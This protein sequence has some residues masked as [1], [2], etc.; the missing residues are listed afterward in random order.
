MKNNYYL[1]LI[2]IFTLG[3]IG[4]SSCSSDDDEV[5]TTDP[6]TLSNELLLHYAF[7][8]NVNDSSI[9]DYNG[10]NFGATFTN[11][12]FGNAASAV[13]FDGVDDYIDLPN[14]IQ[15]K[16]NLP[17]SIA[18][19]IRYDSQDVSDRD[20]FNT[21]FEENRDTGIYYNSQSSTGNYAVNFGDG[22]NNYLSSTRRTYVAD[23]AIEV[24]VWHHVAI[25]ITSG[26]NMD[27][28]IDGVKT[29]GTYSGSGGDLEYSNTSGSI[30][31]HDRSMTE[32]ANHFK[33]AL[34]DFRYWNRE[35]TASEISE[36][37]Q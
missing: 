22:S 32:T 31:R 12:R 17:L 24:N 3:I 21:S 16:P 6:S 36:L 5:T 4:L 8:G 18:F 15:L 13:L 23:Q 29:S 19:W 11:D 7:D 20:V 10:E 14:L 1:K 34:D 37:N 27:I 25:I 9:N 2:G 26:T 30:G 28:Y 35:L 33:G